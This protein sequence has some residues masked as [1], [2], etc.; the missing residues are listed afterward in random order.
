MKARTIVSF[1]ATVVFFFSGAFVDAQ[2]KNVNLY[3]AQIAV[4]GGWVTVLEVLNL[5]TENRSWSFEFFDQ[6]G[7]ELVLKITFRDGGSIPGGAA[8]SGVVAGGV[9]RFILSSMDGKTEVGWAKF[10][11]PVDDK[12]KPE[13]IIAVNY[14]FRD[15]EGK[16]VTAVAVPPDPPVTTAKVVIL[17][18]DPGK[19]TGVAVANPARES[20]S[21]RFEL[22]HST[23][24]VRL[25]DNADRVIPPEGQ[26]AVFADEL[27]TWK[28]LPG[29]PSVFK[30]RADKPVAIMGVRM[31]DGVLYGIPVISE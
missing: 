28:A 21:I 25:F 4:G 15:S 6:V 10:W 19:R 1:C 14:Q 13:I 3:A 26:I 2:Q 12:G 31:D 20:V 29:Y 22:Y 16:T 30:I 18:N 24:E 7:S 11:V 23:G 9:N 17:T 5:S 8:T 27:F